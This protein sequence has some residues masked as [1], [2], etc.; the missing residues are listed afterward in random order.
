MTVTMLTVPWSCMS[1][2]CLACCKTCCYICVAVVMLSMIMAVLSMCMVM[3]MTGR[4]ARFCWAA[5]F[6]GMTSMIMPMGMIMICMSVIMPGRTSL[7]RRMTVSMTMTVT[8]TVVMTA[9]TVSVMPTKNCQVDQIDC[10][11]SDCQ[12]EHQLAV[13]MLWVDDSQ[14]SFID[15]DASHYPDDEH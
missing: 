3:Y 12:N 14:D 9:V 10:Y 8:M 5:M 2:V 7:L 6:V 1:S 4:P 11:A 13:N 15:Q